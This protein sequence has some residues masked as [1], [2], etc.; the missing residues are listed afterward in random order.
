MYERGGM[1]EELEV[2]VC[3]RE[4]KRDHR[5]IYTCNQPPQIKLHSYKESS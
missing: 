3:A 5:P 4:R 1:E 2:C